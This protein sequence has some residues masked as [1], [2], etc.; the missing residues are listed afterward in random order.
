MQSRKGPTYL[1]STPWVGL[2]QILACVTTGRS[3][4]SLRNATND[5]AQRAGAQSNVGVGVC[6][7]VQ[8]VRQ[9]E[10]KTVHNRLRSIQCC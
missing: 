5:G 8:S 2:L 10:R 9:V 7:P 3:I 4:C 6:T 1:G